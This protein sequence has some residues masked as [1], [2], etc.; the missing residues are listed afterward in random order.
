MVILLGF[1]ETSNMVVITPR[2]QLGMGACFARLL[3][4][5]ETLCHIPSK[6]LSCKV[7]DQAAEGLW[8]TMGVP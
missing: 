8:Y 4:H 1:N 7:L 2:P 3:F 5:N 6:Q